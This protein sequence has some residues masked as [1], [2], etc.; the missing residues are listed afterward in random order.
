MDADDVP[1]ARQHRLRCAAAYDRSVG[2]T[3]REIVLGAFDSLP[4]GSVQQATLAFA[5]QG[6]P[7]WTINQLKDARWSS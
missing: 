4:H 5:R 7:W 6:N 3:G 1:S 2:T